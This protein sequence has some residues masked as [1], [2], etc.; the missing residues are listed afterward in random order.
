MPV[1][2]AIVG[3]FVLPALVFDSEGSTYLQ[4]TDICTVMDNS[5]DSGLHYVYDDESNSCVVK[6]EVAEAVK[7][8]GRNVVVPFPRPTAKG[9]PTS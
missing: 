5:F 4:S 6:Q 2:A 8:E 9:K 1:I 3:M 7:E